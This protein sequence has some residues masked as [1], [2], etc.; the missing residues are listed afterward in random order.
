[1]CENPPKCSRE[2]PRKVKKFS[3]TQIIGTQQMRRNQRYHP[4]THTPTHPLTVN[5]SSIL[6]ANLITRRFSWFSLSMMLPQTKR[7]SRFRSFHASK[8]IE[9]GGGRSKK[10]ILTMETRSICRIFG[11]QF[12]ITYCEWPFTK[13]PIEG[14]S[15][16]ICQI[17][18]IRLH[19]PA[20]MIIVSCL[21]ISSTTAQKCPNNFYNIFWR[22]KEKR[23]Y[24]V[25]LIPLL[26]IRKLL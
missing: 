25:S 19:S 15:S 10:S 5:S 4:R 14:K 7:T 9:K 24:R 20:P 8:L 12:G 1:M 13:Q 17:P 3:L 21:S 26:L 18:P 23:A 22:E 11:S 16:V 6:C 2:N